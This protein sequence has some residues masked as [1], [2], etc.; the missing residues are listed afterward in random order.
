MTYK[1]SD[2]ARLPKEAQRLNMVLFT[3]VEC[4]QTEEMLESKS[5]WGLAVASIGL[6]ICMIFTAS[7]RYL[8][9]TDKII[10]AQLDIKLVTVDDFTLQTRLPA[11]LYDKFLETHSGQQT[12]TNGEA[13]IMT[14][15]KEMKQKIQDLL[16]EK[17]VQKRDIVDIHFGFD[18][19][20]LLDHLKNRA[21]KLKE[22]KYDDVLEI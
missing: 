10:D 3:Q 9:N 21:E 22:K 4:T 6:F 17:G 16:R 13:P 19:Q 1:F 5:T 18:N 20:K 14:F 15:K 8:K 11:G 2:F 12:G 7:I